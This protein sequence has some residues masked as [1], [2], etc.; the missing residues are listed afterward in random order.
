MCSSL[1]LHLYDIFT[2]WL[3]KFYLQPRPIFLGLSLIR[4]LNPTQSSTA[5][6]MGST[7]KISSG[8]LIEILN[9]TWHKLNPDLYL[10]KSTLPTVFPSQQSNSFLLDAQSKR[11]E[12]PFT[13][14]FLLHSM[15]YPTACTFETT[16][17]INPES[18]F[19]LPSL[20]YSG[21]SHHRS[22]YCTT[23]TSSLVSCLLFSLCSSLDVALRQLL[24]KQDCVTL[25]QN[26]WGSQISSWGPLSV[27]LIFPLCFSDLLLQ[28]LFYCA[29]SG[30]LAIP[31]ICQS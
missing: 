14:F 28:F 4:L 8:W 7:F 3:P 23:V 1:F 21:L 31:P 25:A 13:V 19:C 2:P 30:H 18:N 22:C 26:T 6:A 20:S 11:S 12:F 5:Y 15:S 27:S 24:W 9:S 10:P 17:K 16:F 29:C